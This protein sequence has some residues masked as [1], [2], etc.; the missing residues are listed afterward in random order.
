MLPR[1]LQACFSLLL[2]AFLFPS[3][4][5]PQERRSQVAEPETP[6]VS[7]PLD[8]GVSVLRLLKFNGLL[9]DRMGQPRTG[10]VGLTFALY[11][12]R[13]GGAPLWMEIQNA[14]LDEQGRYSVLLGST[15]SEG[16]PL[17][18]FTTG[19]PRWLGVQVQFPG[20]EEQPR[21][22]LVS[23]PYA[24]KAA[25]AD[26]LAGKPLAAFVLAPEGGRAAGT[27]ARAVVSTQGVA[28]P[29]LVAATSGTPGYLG[30]F[31]NTTDLGNSVL[32]QLG[33]NI[34]LGT[35]SPQAPLHIGTIQAHRNLNLGSLQTGAYPGI[36]LENTATSGSVAL[37]ENSGLWVFTKASTAADFVLSDLK[38]V[39]NQSGNVGIGTSAPSQK[40]DVAGNV[41]VSGGGVI[42]G[43]GSGLTN[44][45]ASNLSSG[46]IANSRTTA[47]STNSA[48]SIV[49]RDASGNFTAGTVTASSF[50]GGGAGL[51]GVNAALLGGTPPSGYAPA[52][53]STVYV[54]KGGDTMTGTLNLPANG[55]VAGTNQLVLSGSNVGIGTP[56]PAQ[57]LEVAGKIKVTSIIFGNGSEQTSA[58]GILYSQ[59]SPMGGPG[60]AG[61]VGPMADCSAAASLQQIVEEQRLQIEQLR[62]EVE[63]L[64]Q[65]L[66]ALLDSRQ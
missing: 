46:T 59:T 12:D 45:N 1:S 33:G 25:D 54:S 19:E 56:A 43:D 57:K 41:S 21:V 65:R 22:L 20:E 66:D 30:V 8:L 61:S 13:E 62:S 11:K 10:V 9:R 55:L 64:K 32:F 24:L 37:T 50:S 6:R 35:T 3:E 53:G 34:G 29:G 44:L 49:L 18:L 4:I 39:V 51:S 48:N 58:C 60:K 2:A 36:M 63:R 16:L 27:A 52:T 38:M 14:E 40:L 17:E 15:Q 31:V 47:T 23:V 26:T 7:A 5:V 28:G 42:S